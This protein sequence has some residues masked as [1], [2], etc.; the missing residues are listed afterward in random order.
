[1]T[2]VIKNIIVFFLLVCLTV[3]CFTVYNTI[4]NRDFSSMYDPESSEIHSIFNVF[5][6]SYD[7]L[8]LYFQFFPIEFAFDKTTNDTMPKAYVSLFFR[9][10]KTYNSI[11]IIDSLTQNFVFRGKPQLYFFGKLPV[12]LPDNQPY[13]IEIFLTDKLS[14]RSTSKVM[15]IR[16]DN[17]GGQNS[18]MFLSKYAKPIFKKNLNVTDSF[19]VRN[20]LKTSAGMTVQ[21][22]LPLKTPA[23]PPDMV[24]TKNTGDELVKDTIYFYPKIDTS[25]LWF[26]NEGIYVF[27]NK[28]M[29]ESRAIGVFN[30][31]YP[32]L[33]TPKQLLESL[34]YICSEKEMDKLEK[35]N[36]DKQ[37]VDTFWQGITGDLDKAREL[38]RIYYNR[39]QLSNYFFAE[40]KEGW[41]TDRGMIYIVFG[42]PTQVNIN[43]DGETWIYGKDKKIALTFFFYREQHPIY[44]EYFE[45]SRSEQYGRVWFNA[46]SAWRKGKAFSM[47]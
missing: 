9:V 16:K 38:I 42:K 26:K 30:K 10:T 28:N 25:L 47:N 29:K 18:Y 5:Q 33:K 27:K 22:I 45:L 8:Q 7:K 39:V 12:N 35:L 1:M 17:E 31:Y 44:G 46:V 2:S 11:E 15:T 21:K 32:Y 13:V 37:A 4:D 19:R 36:S 40:I 43:K 20:T 14:N 24:N 34:A 3:S 41:L 23:Y 6:P